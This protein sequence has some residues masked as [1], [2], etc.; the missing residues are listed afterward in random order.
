MRKEEYQDI[1]T[2]FPPEDLRTGDWEMGVL[3]SG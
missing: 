2:T 1:F 3:M